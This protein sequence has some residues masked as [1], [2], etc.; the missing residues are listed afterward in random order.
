MQTDPAYVP[1]AIPPGELQIFFENR[2]VDGT[3][4][5]VVTADEEKGFLIMFD[6][7][8]R[9]LTMLA[10]EVRIEM[11]QRLLA[12]VP[13]V[14]T[15]PPVRVTPADGLLPPGVIYFVGQDDPV[16]WVE[17][18]DDASGERT[19]RFETVLRQYTQRL[20]IVAEHATRTL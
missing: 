17:R 5:H 6:P 7:H 8:V 15:V 3:R 19:G 16:T 11:T 12:V 14:L 13:K 18:L 2:Q 20:P 1:G 4:S 9:R 10:G